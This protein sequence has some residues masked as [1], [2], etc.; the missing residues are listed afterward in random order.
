[1][2]YYKY[3]HS[4]FAYFGK[5]ERAKARAKYLLL[6]V[7]DPPLRSLPFAHDSENDLDRSMRIAR[8]MT[9][10]AGASPLAA[11]SFS[12]V[13]SLSFSPPPLPP[14]ALPL[15]PTFSLAVPSIVDPFLV[16]SAATAV[17]CIAAFAVATSLFVRGGFL[18]PPAQAEPS[19]LRLSIPDIS[20]SPPV[21]AQVIKLLSKRN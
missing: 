10:P 7:K 4:T 8:Y 20:G 17:C 1:M 14:A 18:P 11:G 5:K 21:T 16:P 2:F 12:I 19:S 15:S 3:V 13:S 9:R 6:Y